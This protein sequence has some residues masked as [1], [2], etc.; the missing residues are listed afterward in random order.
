MVTRQKNVW[1]G[2]C[3]VAACLTA[4]LFAQESAL[5]E[6]EKGFYNNFAL[7]SYA[8][9]KTEQRL[10]EFYDLFGEYV[11]NG[12]YI[13]SLSNDRNIVSAAT[14]ADST[15]YAVSNEHRYDLFFDNFR[16]LCYSKDAIGGVKTAFIIGDQV[17]TKFTPLTF[18]KRNY[19]GIRYDLW[20][21][22][23]G[24][25]SL[26]SRTRPGLM[27]KR[28]KGMGG[29][30]ALADYNQVIDS[31]VTYPLFGVP[32]TDRHG[33]DWLYAQDTYGPDWTA[34]TMFGDYDFLWAF[35]V[36]Q[37][38][39]DKMDVGLT[40]VNHH[41]SDIK[42]GEKW[43]GDIP[44]ALAPNEIHFEIYDLTHSSQGD[45]GAVLH[46]IQATITTTRG[47]LGHIPAD[48]LF[49]A[50][51]E[52]LTR[53]NSPLPYEK[54][55]NGPLVCTF[56]PKKIVG[57]DSNLIKDISFDL[58]LAGNYL[59]FVSTDRISACDNAYWDRDNYTLKHLQIKDIVKERRGGDSLKVNSLY[60]ENFYGDYI[61]KSPRLAQ[62]SDQNRA[63]YHYA[64]RMPVASQVYGLD[65]NGS[66]FNTNLKGELVANAQ[67]SKYPTDRAEIN[68]TWNFNG[69]LQ[70]DRYLT[71]DKKYMLQ[72]ALFNLSPAYLPY[73]P[74]YQLSQYFTRRHYLENGSPIYYSNVY[75]VVLGNNYTTID[76][77]EDD[78]YYVENNR[79][80]YP[81]EVATNAWSGY[82]EGTRKSPRAVNLPSADS[83]FQIVYDDQDGV[84]PA[85]YD[86]NKN[87]QL[88]Y[89]EDFLLYQADPPK[90]DLEKDKN[91]NGI[92]DAQEDDIYPDYPFLP[93]YTYT[94]NGVKS[95]GV[96][97]L[98]M[99]V[100]YQPLPDLTV[101]VG[102][103]YQ[104][105]LDPDLDGES[106]PLPN[107]ENRA[108]Q[109]Y[110][111]AMYRMARRDQGL[112]ISLGEE[113][114]YVQDAIR[115]DAVEATS[116]NNVYQYYV[117]TDKLRYR[118]ALVSNTA[119]AVN[120]LGLPN[121]ELTAKLALTGE[122]HFAETEKMYLTRTFYNAQIGG[123]DYDKDTYGYS[124]TTI[125]G[126]NALTKLAYTFTLPALPGALGFLQKLQITPQYK[127]LYGYSH[128]AETDP[129]VDSAYVNLTRDNAP[130]DSLWRAAVRDWVLFTA[131]NQ[132]SL[133]SVPIVRAAYPLGEKTSLEF[134]WQWKRNY[135]LL[136][137]ENSYVKQTRVLQIVTNDNYVSF[138][139][140]I[141]VG[142]QWEALQ[143]DF[144]YYNPIYQFGSFWDN[145]KSFVFI[146]L[147]A[148]I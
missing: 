4:P 99:D 103:E 74:T 113:L 129:R 108:L 6:E 83:T 94:S 126:C 73:L 65:F 58:D 32:G 26:I 66:L 98:E 122:Q 41:H 75:P 31:W 3:L 63:T 23:L 16:N 9:E 29:S 78:D 15:T 13:Y 88:D 61:I 137:N 59:V 69:Y 2:V 112:T 118:N 48:S 27:A 11:T 84:I 7:S 17:R 76:D 100:K 86:R 89:N 28:W 35:H 22:S 43:N 51:G 97:G 116:V 109:G 55:G 40:Y 30:D 44:A 39:W 93:V 25:T 20:Y 71:A 148:G 62:T 57:A 128:S 54:S 72:G 131:Y 114:K 1:V 117:S 70:A 145:K 140:A 105:A 142:W 96:R 60:S 42:K 136:I 8:K 45:P 67:K 5:L 68:N 133:L 147:F 134:G 130:G 110:G 79:S 56:Y 80:P 18:N 106:E 81:S 132:H 49:E 10:Q 12:Y 111:R 125:L 135:D 50:N 119:A 92:A 82:N 139:V 52:F 14:Q 101:N 143:Y 115:N 37:R 47:V 36:K 121:F 19:E 38:F 144:N 33:E 120:Y 64:Y 127:M 90:F 87:G 123:I 46:G 141:Q 24:I 138:N 102:V 34:R 95:L 53:L 104:R 124:Q 91:N 146:K 107:K 77:N 21:H 85:R